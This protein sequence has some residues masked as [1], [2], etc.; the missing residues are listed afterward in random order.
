MNTAK[1]VSSANQKKRRKAKRQRQSVIDED[2]YNIKND[3]NVIDYN[4]QNDN[5]DAYDH[6]NVSYDKIEPVDDLKSQTYN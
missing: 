6:R 5:S 1:R 2:N 4:N 3:D